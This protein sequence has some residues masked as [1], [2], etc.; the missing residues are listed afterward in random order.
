MTCDDDYIYFGWPLAEKVSGEAGNIQFSV[1][2]LNIN[3]GK[4]LYNYATKIASCEVKTTLNFNLEDGS[5]RSEAWEDILYTRPVYSSVINSTDSPAAILL[6]GIE[7]GVQDMTKSIE[8]YDT[9]EVDGNDDPIMAE[10][11][12]WNLDIPVIAT[13]STAVKPGTTQELTFKWYR[14]SAQV[15]DTS[16]HTEE[17]AGGEY[18]ERAVKSTFHADSIGTY[19]VWIGNKISDKKN[20]RYIYTGTVTIPGPKDVAMDSSH[21]AP[22]GYTDT[23]A[24]ILIA[25]IVNPN[26]PEYDANRLLYTWYNDDTDEIVQ[27]PSNN[28]RYV[29]TDEGKYYCIVQNTRNGVTTDI[30]NSIALSS[31]A[32]IRVLPQRL[33]SLVLEY[34]DENSVLE[35]TATHAYANHKIEYRWY[36]YDA[37]T[38]GYTQVEQQLTGAQSSYAPQQAGIY[39]VEA[40]EIVFDEETGPLYQRAVDSMRS[41]SNEIVIGADLRPVT[42]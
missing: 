36:R 9:G 40:R 24:A 15:T 11:E 27:G 30:G 34:K 35:A 17:A 39:R 19:T 3:E 4:I 7:T 10:R 33:T 38:S 13:T 16:K 37:E 2:F 23:E 26:D 5:I 21:I 6:Q 31:A 41:V 18:D 32:D 20:V 42:E 14:N 29:A 25:G 12:V 22:K 8:E 1:R 28:P